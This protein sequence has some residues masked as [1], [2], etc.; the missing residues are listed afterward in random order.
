MNNHPI[1]P[2]RGHGAS[3]RAALRCTAKGVAKKSAAALGVIATALVGL[4]IMAAPAGAHHP[5]G[6]LVRADCVSPTDVIQPSGEGHALRVSYTAKP[7]KSTEEISPASYANPHLEIQVRFNGTGDWN[8]PADVQVIDQYLVDESS[9]VPANGS[10]PADE[11]VYLNGPGGTFQ[12][13]QPYLT[14]PLLG[15]NDPTH[16]QAGSFVVESDDPITQVEARFYSVGLW[17]NG[18]TGNPEGSY[19]GKVFFDSEA[20]VP[21]PPVECDAGEQGV[22]SDGDGVADVCEPLPPVE[23]D[24]GEQ[25]ADTDGDG[26]ADTCTEVLTERTPGPGATPQP[27]P[28]S[29]QSPAAL[30]LTGTTPAPMAAAAGMFVLLGLGMVLAA[31]ELGQA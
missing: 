29:A 1:A 8:N 3:A 20:C 15:D 12:A 27:Q 4:V 2:D 18:A 23:C 19:M 28:T 25:G 11:T 6:G 14:F 5:E 22:D 9:I 24:A 31:K 10:D 17:R 16:S 7:W 26:V 13:L 21:T 30:A